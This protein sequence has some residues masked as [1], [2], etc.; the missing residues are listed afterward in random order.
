MVTAVIQRPDVAPP[1]AATA[2]E[3]MRARFPARL[4]PASWPA[5]LQPREAAW[6]RLTRPPFVLD[7]AKS[8]QRRVRGLALLLDWLAAQPGETWQDRWLAAARTVLVPPGGS[9]RRRGCVTAV[10]TV[11]GGRPSCP[12]R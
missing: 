5:T 8:Q 11:S 6:E 1:T 12:R 4:V 9:C 3:S 10:C 7:N 2:R